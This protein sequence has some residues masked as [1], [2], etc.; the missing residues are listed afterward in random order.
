MNLV[1]HYSLQKFE[2]STIVTA[3]IEITKINKNNW[4]EMFP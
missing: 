1:V 3:C 4:C 2:F